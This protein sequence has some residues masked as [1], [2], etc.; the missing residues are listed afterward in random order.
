MMFKRRTYGFERWIAWDDELNIAAKDFMGRFMVPPH[1]ML[2]SSVTYAKIDLAAKKGHL[3]NE[4]GEHPDEA[5]HTPVTAFAGPGFRLQF[6][7]EDRLPAGR[8]SLIYDS[9]PDGP[10]P[11]LDD[12]EDRD[13]AISTAR[14]A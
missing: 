13:D 14:G 3:T 7:I 2:A 4:S 10:G 1:I 11:V 9:D 6:C 5:E 8:F 12:T